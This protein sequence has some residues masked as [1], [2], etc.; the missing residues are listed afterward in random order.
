V[1]PKSELVRIVTAPERGGAGG[2]AVLDRHGTMP[3]RGAYLCR[4]HELGAPGEPAPSCLALAVRSSGIARTLRA[5]VTLD[6]K[7]VESVS[8]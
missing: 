5:R 1:A 7:I 2:L 6:P 3:G 8:R 4:A